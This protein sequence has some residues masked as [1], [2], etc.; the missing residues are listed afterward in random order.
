MLRPRTTISQECLDAAKVE[1]LAMEKITVNKI[2]E[3]WIKRIPGSSKDK[4]GKLIGEPD[5]EYDEAYINQKD[6]PY[7][8][9]DPLYMKM[10]H[11][12]RNCNYRIAQFFHQIDPGNQRLLLISCIPECY[13]RDSGLACEMVTFMAWL[14]NML[15]KADLMFTG[16]E[17]SWTEVELEQQIAKWQTTPIKWFFDLAPAVQKQILERYI[18]VEIHD[19]N[20]YQLNTIQKAMSFFKE[21]ITDL[22]SMNIED[23]LEAS[24]DSSE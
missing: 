24:D 3:I 14:S 9:D 18:E 20:V 21:Q 23:G 4:Q 12:F 19:R 5:V 2:K 10:I 15:G 8:F 13:R 16:R 11:R 6:L 7:Q 22:E 1:L 17:F